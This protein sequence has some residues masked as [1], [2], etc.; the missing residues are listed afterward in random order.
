MLYICFLSE[1]ILKFSTY[2]GCGWWPCKCWGEFNF[3]SCLPNMSYTVTKY[4]AK[5][6][7]LNTTIKLGCQQF[8]CVALKCRA[9]WH[10][11]HAVTSR[12]LPY[13]IVWRAL[14]SNVLGTRSKW[15]KMKHLR[16]TLKIIRILALLYHY[17]QYRV[18]SRANITAVTFVC[19]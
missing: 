18:V 7:R 13:S 12:V 2:F 16:A 6:Y 15:R 5:L 11:P 3:Y 4:D 10:L 8:V 17:W 14:A 19:S 9:H 1:A